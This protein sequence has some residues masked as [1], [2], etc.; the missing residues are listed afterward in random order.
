MGLLLND[1]FSSQAIKLDLEGN[2]KESAF[3]E[4]SNIISTVHPEYEQTIIL[5][6]LWEREEKLS[7][8]IAPGFAIP[9]A[10]LKGNNKIAGAIGISKTGIEYGALDKGK[11]YV[12]FMLAMGESAID[13]HLFVLNQ[14]LLLAQSEMYSKIRN[15]AN[16]DDVQ[17][18]LTGFG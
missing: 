10:L 16:V 2:T 11:V 5:K 8:G 18:I 15:A 1:I 6:S 12:V 17:A 14:I 7:T 4:L 9:H 3:I 13:K